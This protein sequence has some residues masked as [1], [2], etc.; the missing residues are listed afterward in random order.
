MEEQLLVFRFQRG[1][2]FSGDLEYKIY[3]HDDGKLLFRSHAS[4]C[5]CGMKDYEFLMPVDAINGIVKLVKSIKNWEKAYENPDEI[6]DGYGWSIQL[7]YGD[8]KFS[9]QGYEAYPE[10]YR[11]VVKTIQKEIEKICKKY[12]IDY[13]EDGKRQRLAL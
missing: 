6:L 2:F 4:N 10:N 1:A 3:R 12:A 9:S 11:K 5:F 7:A 8:C 13:S